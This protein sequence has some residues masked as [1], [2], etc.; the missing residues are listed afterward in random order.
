MGP[1]RITTFTLLVYHSIKSQSPTEFHTLVYFCVTISISNTETVAQIHC[2]SALWSI[3]GLCWTMKRQLDGL[4][5]S[6]TTQV[7][8]SNTPVPPA[9]A[10]ISLAFSTSLL[11]SELHVLDHL[12]ALNAA[13]WKSHQIYHTSQQWRWY[14]K[15]MDHSPVTNFLFRLQQDKYLPDK[16]QVFTKGRTPS[17]NPF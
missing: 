16:P 2:D 7:V 9:E 11:T 13:C 3:Y 6:P 14:K 4:L 17:L 8:V 12:V 5:S 15:V 10:Q 1:R